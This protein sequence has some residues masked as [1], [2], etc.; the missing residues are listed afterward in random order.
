MKP[1]GM[2]GE[3]AAAVALRGLTF[4]AS[5]VPRF[6]RFLAMTGIG[7][8]ELRASAGGSGLQTAVLEYL[9]GDESLLLVFASES[10]VPASAIATAHAVLGGR[11]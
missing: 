10:S 2:D 9:L 5:D 1:S 6:S 8:D 7:P 4:L 11:R 3:Q